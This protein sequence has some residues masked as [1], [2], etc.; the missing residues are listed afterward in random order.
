MLIVKQEICKFIM[1]MFKMHRKFNLENS[2]LLT[3]RRGVKKKVTIHFVEEV[4]VFKRENGNSNK[5]LVEPSST[6]FHV[7]Q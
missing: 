2:G 7:S 6:P 5:S 4:G 1:K 3:S